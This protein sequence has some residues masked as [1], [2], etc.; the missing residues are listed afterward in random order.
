MNFVK[1][2]TVFVILLCVL[3]ALLVRKVG[4]RTASTAIP[5]RNTVTSAIKEKEN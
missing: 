3:N 4:G 5:Q 2:L 1:P